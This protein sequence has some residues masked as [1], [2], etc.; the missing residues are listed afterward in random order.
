MYFQCHEI[1]QQPKKVENE[2]F[3]CGE[4]EKKKKKGVLSEEDGYIPNSAPR[5]SYTSHLLMK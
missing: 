1:E 2:E 4:W 3:F 5:N